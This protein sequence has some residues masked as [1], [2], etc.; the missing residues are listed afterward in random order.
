MLSIALAIAVWFVAI[1]AYV[2]IMAAKPMYAELPLF[3]KVH[4][5]PLAW[6]GL[7]ADFV[8]NVWFGTLMFLEPPHELLFS[9]RVQRHVDESTGWR[10]RLARFWARQLNV[11]HKTH[12]KIRRGA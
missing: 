1:W 5:W 11:F 12:I 4:L 8:F 6:L 10:G 2:A 3:W 9:S 7:V